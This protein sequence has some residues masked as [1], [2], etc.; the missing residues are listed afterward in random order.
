[1]SSGAASRTEPRLGFQAWAVVCGPGP[2]AVLSLHRCGLAAARWAACSPTPLVSSQPQNDLSC[3]RPSGGGHCL[4][5][6]HGPSELS[7][8]A[9]GWGCPP[10]TE[11][12]WAA[13][14]SSSLGAAGGVRV[15]PQV[16]GSHWGQQGSSP[17]LAC[18]PGGGRV[19]AAVRLI[20]PIHR[21]G[22]SDPDILW[23]LGDAALSL[24]APL[25]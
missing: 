3:G 8:L 10:L 4:A 25:L 20:K 7:G 9:R 6:R 11:Q 22:P 18:R 16:S 21:T 17:E 5:G 24:K 12:A 2:L 19:S 23:S 14:P 13:V 15:R 1:M